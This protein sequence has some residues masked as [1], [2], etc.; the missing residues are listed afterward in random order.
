MKDNFKEVEIDQFKDEDVIKGLEVCSA[1]DWTCST[2]CPYSALTHGCICKLT[3]DAYDLTNRQKAEI[4]TLKTQNN[5]LDRTY[6]AAKRKILML[7][8][9]IQNL[10][11]EIEALKKKRWQS[12]Q[13][14][15]ILETILDDKNK[16][17]SDLIFKER[18][19]AILEF[20]EQLKNKADQDD[21]GEEFVLMYDIDQLVEEMED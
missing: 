21:Y 15:D 3:G 4:E 8:G 13:D 19:N 20:V 10:K 1:S 7:C 17:I 2:G 12:E 9:R 14:A 11:N 5:M 6:Q 18:N 16:D